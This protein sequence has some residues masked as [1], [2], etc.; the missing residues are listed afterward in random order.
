MNQH[1]RE[2]ASTTTTAETTTMVVPVVSR[3]RT[4]REI[5]DDHDEET[6]GYPLSDHML[7]RQSNKETAPSSLNHPQHQQ[8]FTSIMTLPSDDVEIVTRQNPSTGDLTTRDRNDYQPDKE[9]VQSSS[10]SSSSSSSSS[11]SRKKIIL[12]YPKRLPRQ[13]GLSKLGIE[14]QSYKEEDFQV[15]YQKDK[16]DDCM[17]NQRPTTLQHFFSSHRRQCIHFPRNTLQS[18]PS[19]YGVII[20]AG[21]LLFLI[22]L[23][24]ATSQYWIQTRKDEK[25]IQNSKDVDHAGP[26]GQSPSTKRKAV[27]EEVPSEIRQVVVEQSV[28]LTPPTPPSPTVPITKKRKSNEDPISSHNAK[29]QE[30]EPISTSLRRQRIDQS[31]PCNDMNDPQPVDVSNG[32]ALVNSTLSS[33]TS[34]D[35]PTEVSAT[36]QAA[37]EDAARILA[38]DIQV[39]QR[40]FE[41]MTLDV[42]LAPQ[43]AFQLRCSQHLLLAPTAQHQELL[44]LQQ[45]ESIHRSATPQSLYDPNWMDKL[46]QKR[47]ESWNIAC[48]ILW[49]VAL[50][51]WAIRVTR[52]VLQVLRSGEGA[53]STSADFGQLVLHALCDCSSIVTS[54]TIRTKGSCTSLATAEEGTL[55]VYLVSSTNDALWQFWGWDHVSYYYGVIEKGACYGY[56]FVSTFMLLA[57]AVLAHQLFRA[58]SAPVMLHHAVNVV[59]LSVLSSSSTMPF[60]ELF[61]IIPFQFVGLLLIGVASMLAL[62][63]WQYQT[64]RTLIRET[65]DFRAS[66]DH[67]LETM[68]SLQWRISMTRYASLLITGYSMTIWLAFPP[69]QSSSL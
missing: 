36:H 45:R 21:I 53:L 24:T 8:L 11:S 6:P 61:R 27:V 17:A 69:V 28:A 33:A 46:R 20:F 38:G 16:I 18:P 30:H 19:S 31:L 43:L 58:F 51:H 26:V 23:G 66:W 4:L 2:T 48:R 59:V 7:D 42:S 50:V 12:Q 37:L 15:I 54:A 39:V 22:F 9:K 3:K 34:I 55:W 57:T 14:L 10:P 62:V 63:Q 60:A 1:N 32:D 56:C 41:Q 68:D 40:V 65:K 52:P 64:H 13:R 67:C 29:K 44:L 25:P 35:Q 47:D 5:L 49:E